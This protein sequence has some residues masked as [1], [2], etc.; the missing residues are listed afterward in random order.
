MKDILTLANKALDAW[1]TY[2]ATR[3][4]AYQI[5]LDKKKEAALHMA[6]CYFEKAEGLV[7][8]IKD[9][10]PK[11]KKS[12]FDFFVSKMNKYK[13]KFNKYD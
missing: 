13:R 10:I 4:K 3:E 2:L 8:L 12:R 9:L 7:E 11:D 6:E 1:K 5:H